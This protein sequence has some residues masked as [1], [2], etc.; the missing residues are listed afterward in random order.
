M[1]VSNHEASAID[2][3]GL[4]GVFDVKH[5]KVTASWVS[6]PGGTKPFS[7][8]MA[9][10]VRTVAVTSRNAADDLLVVGYKG[11]AGYIHKFGGVDLSIDAVMKNNVNES[12]AFGFQLSDFDDVLKSGIIVYTTNGT[13]GRKATISG[14]YVNQ[15]SFNFNQNAES[16]TSW[17]FVGD[18]LDWDN[19]VV[20]T[21][22]VQGNKDF[23]C[24]DPLT[25]DEIH[26]YDGT[27]SV[28]LTGVQ[29]A[30]IQASINRQDVFQ[31]GQFAPYDRAVVRPYKVSVNLDLLANDVRLINWWDKFRPAYNPDDD[32]AAGLVI[33]IRTQP[34]KDDLLATSYDFIIASGL[35][36]TTSTLNVA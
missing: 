11:H 30:T 8:V 1:A 18:G 35:R 31:I 15:I 22:G 29:R 10:A 4:D 12:G 32:C 36:P 33:K 13:L 28:L 24:I 25:W 7:G 9:E 23:H 3:Q 34:L 5:K 14:L 17:N 26:L 6:L 21:S 27:N 19:Y 20:S 16:T 2:F